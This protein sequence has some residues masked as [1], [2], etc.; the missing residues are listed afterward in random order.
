[1]REEELFIY[2]DVPLDVEPQHS[3]CRTKLICNPV[4]E[5]MYQR[6]GKEQQGPHLHIHMEIKA[7]RRQEE[8]S[9]AEARQRKSIEAQHSKD[10]ESGAERTPRKSKKWEE[11]F[12]QDQTSLLTHRA[13]GGGAGRC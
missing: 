2:L 7:K 5:A 12:D 6:Q 13:P 9:C 8:Q 11:I 1:M 3:H 4:G 10:D